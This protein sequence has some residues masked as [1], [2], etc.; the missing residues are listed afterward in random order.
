SAKTPDL[1]SETPDQ[2]PLSDVLRS[3]RLRA[4]IFKQGSYCGAWALEPTGVTQ[5]IFHLIGRG[6][7][8]VH[9]EGV[10]EPLIVGGGDLVMFP[11]GSWHQLSGVPHRLRGTRLTAAGEGPFTTVLCGMVE[12]VV[13]GRT[14]V[15]QSLPAA[16]IVRG[17]DQ[18]TSA[19]L[20][21]LARLMLAEY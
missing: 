20:H 5:T 9:T 8:W 3:L 13:A 14:S 12:F 7:A 17:E 4:R 15:M 11:H 10:R 6:Q 19:H 16:I 18:E 1:I 21:A 2:D